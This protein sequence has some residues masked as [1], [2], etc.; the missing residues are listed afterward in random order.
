MYRITMLCVLVALAGV[1]S[2]YGE[3]L[4]I[5]NGVPNY[6]DLVD[7]AALR[8][9]GV[10]GEGDPW[11]EGNIGNSTYYGSHRMY[12]D[13]GAASGRG[14]RRYLTR[15]DVSSIPS[16]ATIISATMSLWY[17]RSADTAEAITGYKLSRLKAGKS[18][19]EGVGLS[20]ATDGSV[21]WNC[22]V[23]Y[24][25]GNPSRLP[26]ATPGATGDA[27]IDL[28]TT[29][30]F[31]KSGPGISE[32]KDFN[33][34]S[35]VQAWVDG[36][37][38]NNGMVLWGG[39]GTGVN[40][41]YGICGSETTDVS[42]NP[43]PKL[44]VNYTVEELCRSEVTPAGPQSV[45]G[46]AGGA[47]V[48]FA[49]IDLGTPD[50]ENGLTHLSEGDGDTLST[51]AAGRPCRTNADPADD[52]YMYFAVDDGLAFGGSQPAVTISFDY[53][54]GGTGAFVLHY[55]SNT[56]DDLP[57]KYKDGGS[58]ALTGTNAWKRG[59]FTVT[60][61]LF[62]NRQNYGGDFRIA[63]PAGHFYLDYVSVAVTGNHGPELTYTIQ[64][65]GT[66]A[67]TWTAIEANAD[68]TAHDY[69][70]LILTPD[71]GPL[72]FQGSASVAAT[73]DTT[74]LGHGPQTAYVKFTDACPVSVV[75]CLTEPFT[76]P[77]G[78][79]V[80][81]GGWSGTAGA[82]VVDVLSNEIRLSPSAT[83][84]NAFIN[85]NC[86]YE[87]VISVKIKAK[88]GIGDA[89]IQKFVV[90]DGAN[91]SG[92]ILGQ[93]NLSSAAARAIKPDTLDQY[94]DIPLSSAYKELEIRIHTGSY[95]TE[96]L[97]DD[98]LQ[99]VYPHSSSAVA[100]VGSVKFMSNTRSDASGQYL[101]MDDLEVAVIEQYKLR[102]ITLDV[103]GCGYTVEPRTA[104]AAA[105]G[106]TTTRS[107]ALINNGVS[108]LTDLT[109]VEIT[110]GGVEG[111]IYPWLSLEV[112][113]VTLAP[114]ESAE[115][116]A[117]IDWSLV[118]AT[119]VASLRFRATC[120]GLTIQDSLVGALTVTKLIVPPDPTIL[121][122]NGDVD[123]LTVGFERYEGSETGT[124]VSTERGSGPTQTEDGF[125]YYIEDLTTGK[126][127]LRTAMP[128]DATA[129]A[130]LLARVMLTAEG[131]SS[132]DLAGNLFILDTV[133]GW[134]YHLSVTDQTYHI[135]RIT[136]RA[137]GGSSGVVIRVYSDEY[138]T[139]ILI[140]S[141]Q[142]ANYGFDGLAFGAGGTA[143]SQNIYFDWVTGT[144][145]GAFAPG[146]EVPCLGRSLVPSSICLPA[147]F[148]D[149]DKDGDVDQED[150]SV[151]QLCYTGGDASSIPTAPTYC[152]C[153]NQG[154][155]DNNGQ[156]DNDTDIDGF[157]RT[158]FERCASGP[159][160]LADVCCDGVPRPECP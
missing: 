109:A 73:V 88:S 105:C 67:T 107:F 68:G 154:D 83:D 6:L 33:I 147:P 120:G 102:R 49:T 155:D 128:I 47:A 32:W 25:V 95:R 22:Q 26:W 106:G 136:A 148:A 82:G 134:E 63:G 135:I 15:F 116:V 131:G 44:V 100:G 78:A 20:P 62:S 90:L 58:I 158:A 46:Y 118:S 103:I 69:A 64:N 124:V 113:S 35:W 31:D 99:V 86:G 66:A 12:P 142:G 123:P 75:T 125:A 7:D 141:N 14:P 81:N 18:W 143:W 54:D 48:P 36:S 19:A 13:Q 61:A 37:W 43:R 77:D 159:G 101:T 98:V 132:P 17:Q 119:E 121:E 145:A 117:T 133:I 97:V 53:F 2:A 52:F 40:Q 27:D 41:Y 80:G 111:D 139:P 30:T 160:V 21:T 57:A 70:W 130:T 93:W 110:S 28:A 60:D 151:F 79:L 84:A 59:S 4:T 65:T 89:I 114:G 55:D 42:G 108:D 140:L 45:T 8:A 94:M 137:E 156:P 56:G 126:I 74:S 39:V 112:P 1:G 144:N 16:N 122:Y 91:G 3:T 104:S 85:V 10:D 51:A 23:T 9:E 138:P 157:D 115:V 29:F 76:Y 38:Q 96:Y 129:G 71:T 153:L 34:T 11:N 87:G 146:E 92:N 24:P 50:V 149:V 127:K 72:A 150:F 5:A 152:A